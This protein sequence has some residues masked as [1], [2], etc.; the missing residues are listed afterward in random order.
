MAR[1]NVIHLF[2]FLLVAASIT[3]FAQPAETG[4]R[5]FSHTLGIGNPPTVFTVKPNGTVTLVKAQGT[6]ATAFLRCEE[7]KLSWGIPKIGESRLIEKGC[8]NMELFANGL[9]KGSETVSVT[10]RVDD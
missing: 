6:N 4:Q 7:Y 3:I 2:S 10:V 9:A 5:Q 1:K 8:P